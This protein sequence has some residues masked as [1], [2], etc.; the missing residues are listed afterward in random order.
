MII[1]TA[2]KEILLDEKM[3]TEYSAWLEEKKNEYDI[4][5]SLESMNRLKEI[6][7]K[8]VNGRNESGREVCSEG[9]SR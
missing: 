3:K 1:I 7:L 8:R 2:I 9:R 4:E 6:N 5:N